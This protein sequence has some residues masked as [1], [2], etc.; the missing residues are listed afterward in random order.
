MYQNSFLWGFPLTRKYRCFALCSSYSV[1]LPCWWETFWSL[2]PSDV[3][4]FFTNQCT[5]SS[6]T[7]P[8]WTSSIPL[9]DT[10]TDQWPAPGK[11]N[12][13]LRQPHAAGLHHALFWHHWGLCPYSHGLWPL[14]CHLQASPLHDYHEQD[15]MQSPHRGCLGWW[16]CP[17]L[18]SVLYGSQF[19]L[20][21]PQWNWPLLLWHFSFVESCLYWYLHH[22]CP[23]GCQFRNGCL[24]NLCS[25]VWVLC[26][27]I[28][29]FK[30][31]L[32]WRKAQSPLYLWVSHHCGYL[33]FWS[34]NLC[35]PQTPYYF[36]WGQNIFSLLYHHCSYVQSLN[37]HSEK[38]RDEK[39]HE[40]GLV[41]K[42]VFR[43]EA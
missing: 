27:Y 38:H 12:H 39:G 36:P 11:E 10:H 14:C 21:W 28:I 43:R 33:I 26:H 18:F 20:L 15:K 9:C 25:L 37:L 24:S 3:A 31:P 41:P 1:M 6:A 19:A 30:K 17:C 42:D 13:L 2:P 34:F 22:W 4:L 29:H 5:T 7:H 23:C 32:S 35:L 8:P 16:G 40:K